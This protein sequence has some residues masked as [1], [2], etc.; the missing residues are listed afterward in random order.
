M[1]PR[2]PGGPAKSHRLARIIV[3]ATHRSQPQVSRATRNKETTGFGVA[4]ARGPCWVELSLRLSD[5]EAPLDRVARV[6][7]QVQVAND[8]RAQV[9]RRA[10]LLVDEQHVSPVLGDAPAAMESLLLG[11]LDAHS[12]AVRV[13]QAREVAV[14]LRGVEVVR[15]R[16]VHL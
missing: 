4:Q 8:V 5:P 11:E 14:I 7:R 2:M 10:D 15:I 6:E 12:F 16:S 3:S 9:V 13:C 1:Y